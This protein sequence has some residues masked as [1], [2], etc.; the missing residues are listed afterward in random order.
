MSEYTHGGWIPPHQPSA[1]WRCDDP[2]LGLRQGQA[3]QPANRPALVAVQQPV[4]ERSNRPAQ[5]LSAGAVTG[6]RVGRRPARRWSIG[7]AGPAG[8]PRRR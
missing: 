3:P 7:M 2:A 6:A 8:G 1:S 5:V 4:E